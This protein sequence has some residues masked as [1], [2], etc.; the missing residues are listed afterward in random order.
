M[1]ANLILGV[2]FANK[3]LYHLFIFV[4]CVQEARLKMQS[5][6]PVQSEDIPWWANNRNNP[7]VSDATKNIA[8]SVP[9]KVQK[10]I[11]ETKSQNPKINRKPREETGFSKEVNNHFAIVKNFFN[12]Y[13]KSI[14]ADSQDY[15]RSIITKEAENK[16]VASST[17]VQ[18]PL[19][20]HELG[21]S[22]DVLMGY[23]TLYSV[24][25]PDSILEDLK[26]LQNDEQRIQYLDTLMSKANACTKMFN[27][28]NCTKYLFEDADWKILHNGSSPKTALLNY[29]DSMILALSN[30]IDGIPLDSN[31][32]SSGLRFVLSFDGKEKLQDIYND[33]L[34]FRLLVQE[35]KDSKELYH[36]MNSSFSQDAINS[37]LKPQDM[38]KF[39]ISEDQLRLKY[40]TFS[41]QGIGNDQ[42]RDILRGLCESFM[43][44][45]NKMAEDDALNNGYI[46]DE[47]G[48]KHNIKSWFE[49]NINLS[50]L[51][52]D[53]NDEDTK[54]FLR[55][56]E[57]YGLAALNATTAIGIMLVSKSNPNL[58]RFMLGL[59]GGV[60]LYEG[61]NS[62]NIN[63]CLT[64]IALMT[65]FVA[66][67]IIASSAT[68]LRTIAILETI[69]Q[70]TASAYLTASL[71]SSTLSTIKGAQNTYWRFDDF[72][73]IGTNMAL[74]FSSAIASKNSSE[75]LKRNMGD[76][77]GE[78]TYF[79]VNG[80]KYK[81]QFYT[82]G[83]HISHLNSNSH[84][85]LTKEAF[86]D[87]VQ[88]QTNSYTKNSQGIY[89]PNELAS[90][91]AN[92]EQALVRPSPISK[93]TQIIN[94]LKSIELEVIPSI[95]N[96]NQSNIHQVDLSKQSENIASSEITQSSSN[97]KPIT[98]HP[99]KP[100][101]V[102]YAENIPVELFM[103]FKQFKISPNTVLEKYILEKGLKQYWTKTN[104]SS[105][106]SSSRL[107]ENKFD[108]YHVSAQ[109]L[110]KFRNYLNNEIDACIKSNDVNG[111]LNILNSGLVVL[112]K[113]IYWNENKELRIQTVNWLLQKTGKQPNELIGADF[114]ANSLS[115]LLTYY[116]GSI[117]KALTE[118]NYAY[119]EQEILNMNNNFDLSAKKLYPWELNN[120]PAS[121]FNSKQM[122][123]CAINW[124]LQKTGKQ[125]SELSS[126]DFH[127][128][129]LRG[130]IDRYS[131][132]LYNALIESNYAYTEQEILNMNNNFILSAKKVYPWELNN[133]PRGLFDSK[134]M[135]LC[136]LNWLLQ[137]TGKEPN[138]LSYAD[139]ENNSLFS[140]L[141]RYFH[142]PYNAL[143]ESGYAYTNQEV[144]DMNNNFDLSAK[145]L[146][147]WELTNSPQG[148]FESQQMRICAL[149]WLLQKSGKKPSKLSREDFLNNSLGG[150]IQTYYSGSPYKALVESGHAY[151]EQEILNMNNNF[152]LSAKKIY[153]WELN[154]S[155]LGIFD[156]QQMRIC[157]LNWLLQKSGKKPSKLSR[158]D[159][160]NNS[161]GGLIDHNYYGSPYKALVESGYAYT[162]QEVL[163]MNNIFDLSAK[164]IYPWELSITPK[165]LFD[166]KE[167][168]ICAVN[169]LLQKSG[170]K[171]SE[172]SQEDFRNNSLGGLIDHNYYGSPYKALVESGYAYT[173]QEVLEM[174]NIFDLSAKK[175]YPWELNNNPKNLFDSKEM[176]LCALN[177]LLQKTGKQPSKLTSADFSKNSL[178]GLF[179]THYSLD[180]QMVIEEL[181]NAQTQN[182][183]TKTNNSSDISNLFLNIEKIR[184]SLRAYGLSL[185]NEFSNPIEIRLFGTKLCDVPSNQFF[186]FYEQIIKL[187]E[188]FAEPVYSTNYIDGKEISRLD[189]YYSVADYGIS[190]LRNMQFS[191]DLWSKTNTGNV[192]DFLKAVNESGFPHVIY[193]NMHDVKKLINSKFEGAEIL[194]SKQNII[195]YGGTKDV[196]EVNIKLNN[197]KIKSVILK[198]EEYPSRL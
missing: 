35:S 88:N 107:P 194:S 169:W 9:I 143:V 29:I 175:L 122:R 81:V 198:F 13:K 46:I 17:Y 113:R 147:P 165:N 186:T 12:K 130:L 129:S 116:S 158:E 132:S 196:F 149:N 42:G 92:N 184:S 4:V 36:I 189:G 185:E 146:Y 52:L 162:N 180:V 99:Q 135:R 41:D 58:S 63:Q 90:N 28:N 133:S 101:T 1:N 91:T 126:A 96:S 44:L 152:V 14:I 71:V 24:F 134:E 167:M 155:P 145:K 74:L 86:S 105:S 188:N 27:I 82:K 124:L 170:K 50:K 77:I 136:A 85:F 104:E 120:S 137:K 21:I 106:S 26:L 151:S 87:F 191:Y 176:R 10:Q 45:S 68:S 64:S 19:T 93:N 53:A 33:L 108:G 109:S 25:N 141:N 154:V 187:H 39:G 16:T 139:F 62:G 153:P 95:N 65:P 66:T 123:I 159:F 138:E 20:G 22:T 173:N 69:V 32:K 70:P 97:S 178:Y 8:N 94:P 164:K 23:P 182:S 117:Y 43:S 190:P 6:L 49:S 171:P 161:L 2:T 47:L 84:V 128:N 131:N 15:V 78:K 179:S 119:T 160:L 3:L 157:A 30:M 127:N 102:S 34:F 60:G 100:T 89:V 148:F 75:N 142:S 80:Q 72:L 125:P 168:R 114:R 111:L 7:I 195:Q 83:V 40:L 54:R 76:A 48:V 37:V 73:S 59:M 192:V 163:E 56:S 140:L 121:L 183:S 118:S 31:T 11:E 172:V 177:W 79:D 156:S 197:G 57:K 144:L 193:S 103:K 67:K 112:N 181:N 115:G 18:K 166:S 98:L 51:G 150:L 110:L 55:Y 5:H 38:Q 174:N 61:I